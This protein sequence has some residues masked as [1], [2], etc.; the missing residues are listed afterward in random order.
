MV[1]NCNKERPGSIVNKTLKN[2]ILT[3]LDTSKESDFYADFKYISFIEFSIYHQKLLTITSPRKF[4]LFWKIGGNSPKKE[5]E[6]LDE[7]HTIAFSISV[8]PTLDKLRSTK[9]CNF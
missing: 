8:N 9:V 4:A 1:T 6:N 5:K 7:N 3:L 2:G